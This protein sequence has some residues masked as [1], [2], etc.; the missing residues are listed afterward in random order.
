MHP[1]IVSVVSFLSRRAVSATPGNRCSIAVPSASRLLQTHSCVSCVLQATFPLPAFHLPLT[2][3]A[4]PLVRSAVRSI[5][6][7]HPDFLSG[8]NCTLSVPPN[9]IAF[10]A[11]CLFVAKSLNHHGMSASAQPCV[12]QHNRAQVRRMRKSA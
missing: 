7:H 3:D 9:H 12:C 6:H 11:P 10:V 1:Y 5:S 2:P 8:C 4:C